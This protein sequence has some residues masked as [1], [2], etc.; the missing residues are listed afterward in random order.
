M[1]TTNAS[2]SFLVRDSKSSSGSYSLSIRDAQ[3]V[4][5]HK[6]QKLDDGGYFV[7]PQLTFETIPKLVAHYSESSDGLLKSPCIIKKLQT[8]GL[9][10]VKDT[11]SEKTKKLTQNGI[12]TKSQDTSP[13]ESNFPLFVGKYDYLASTD[14]HLSFKAGDLLYI[15]NTDEGDWWFA[16]SKNTGQEGYI[17]NNYVAEYNTLDAEE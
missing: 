16:R 2:G 10:T 15:M 13:L 9:S 3:K 5:H 17:P 8:S 12:V 11:F 14:N 6:I 7:T 4:K 1:D